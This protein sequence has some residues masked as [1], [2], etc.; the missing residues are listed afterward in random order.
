MWLKLFFLTLFFFP[1]SVKAE[2]LH[3]LA[4][5]GDPRYPVGYTHFDYANPNAPKGGELRLSKSGSFDNLNNHV[6]FGNNAE[7]LELVNDKLM[8]RAWNEPFT[9]YGL[10]A[11]K[12]DVPEDRSSITFYLRQEARFHDGTPMTSEDVKYSYEMYRAHGHPVRRRVYGLVKEVEIVSSHVIKFSFGEGYDRESVLILAMMPVLPRH[13]WEKNHFPK[14]TLNIPLGSG[15]Y[16][17][18]EVEP[19]RKIVY[20]R[21]KDYW[22]KDLPLNIGH[23]NFDTIS[24]SYFRDDDIALQA[25]KAG[26]YN[27]RIENDIQKWVTSYDQKNIVKEELQHQRPEWLRGFIFNTRRPVFQDLR[28]RRAISLMFNYAWVNKN[29]YFGQYQPITSLFPNATLAATGVPEG[30]ELEWLQKYKSDLSPDVFG[31]AW[32]PQEADSRTLQKQA[33]DLLKEA[34]WQIKD[35]KLTKTDTGEAFRFEILLNDVSAEKIALE[36]SRSLKKIGIDARVRTVDSA[37]FIGRID[38]FD[39]DMVLHRWVNSLSPGNE[40]LNYWGSVAAKNKGTRNY[41]GIDNPAI[42]ALAASIATATTRES[43]VA[44]ARALDRA[45]MLGYYMVPLF[46]LG[47]DLVAYAPDI[48][49]PEINPIYGITREV[50]WHERAPK[51]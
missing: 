33:M 31:E 2:I 28:V 11:E 3:A 32:R 23:Y 41:A 47:K 50:W 14:T 38:D 43:L 8:Q 12:V 40:Q 15:P 1:V 39:Y 48:R 37:Q 20:E 19:G 16:R 10:V 35:Q 5:H 22:A 51:P 45:V 46:Y 18:K 30:E 4:M 9:L 21:V 26:E 42:D 27:F 34:G 29:F 49:R 13:Y 7:W 25:F 36:F 6:I 17:I 44:R 24:I